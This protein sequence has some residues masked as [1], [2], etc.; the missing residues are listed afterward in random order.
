MRVRR[1]REGRKTEKRVADTEIRV[2]WSA[3]VMLEYLRYVRFNTSASDFGDLIC[4]EQSSVQ[5]GTRLLAK[6][7]V[8][9]TA[10]DKIKLYLEIRVPLV[11]IGTYKLF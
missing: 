5:V 10:L 6:D 2:K 1:G 3:D 8:I 11:R 7:P 4:E 9:F